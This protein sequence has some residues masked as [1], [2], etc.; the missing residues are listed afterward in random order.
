VGFVDLVGGNYALSALSPY[1]NAATDGTDIGVD[2]TALNA[3]T[4]CTLSG[5]CGGSAPSLSS[6]APNNVAA[7]SAGFVLTA[8]GSNFG[9]SSVVQWNGTNRMTA[10]V[11][12]TQLQATILATDVATPGTAQVTVVN[13]AP[14]GGTSNALTFTTLSGVSLAV[15]RAGTGSGT[16]TSTP[17]GINCGTSCS[18]TF[19]SGA[20]VVLTATSATGSVFTGWSGGGCSG[21]GACTVTLSAPTTVTATF[22]LQTFT[23]TVSKAGTGSGTVTSSPA[24]ITCGTTCSA[25]FASGTAV[26]LTAPPATGS[27][28][29]GWSGGGCSGTGACTVTLSAPTTVTASLTDTTPPTVSITAPLAAATVSGTVTV[30][31]TAADNVGVAGV[32][33][34]LDGVNL[35]AEVTAAPYT[36]AW[37][38]TTAANGAHALT[39]VARDAAGNRTTSSGVSVTVANAIPIF[40]PA[41]GLVTYWKFDEGTGT[42]AGDSSGNGNTGTLVNGPAW[43]AGK[44]GQALLFDGLTNYVSVP[45]TAA[46][47]SYPLTVAFWM[48][49]SAT[50]GVSGIVSKYVAGSVNGYQVFMNAGNLCAWYL[51]DA[52]NYVYDGSAC[53][54]STSGYND[55]QW[56]YVTFTVDAAGG[57]LY[58]DGLPKASLGWTGTPGA[59]TTTQDL[60]IGHYPGVVGGGFFQG[61]LDDVRIYDPSLSAADVLSLYGAVTPG[62]PPVISGVAASNVSYVGA[63][64]TWTTNVSSD[65]QVEYGRTTAYGSSTTQNLSLVTSHSQAL[66]GLAPVTVYHYRVKSRDAAGI[67]ATS[68][69]GTFMTAAP[70]SDTPQRH[71]KRSNFFDEVT[72]FFRR[73]F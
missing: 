18:A 57:K 67:L 32:Q 31:A 29:S 24:G 30:T 64:I 65:S 66:S 55:N 54:L 68:A 12:G 70:P 8:S 60:H 19:A 62:S 69:D 22:T 58:V 34:L 9:S 48:K 44:L 2:F 15:V 3:A 4:A 40:N 43:T 16:V 73:L 1:K 36:V 72:K 38:T 27:T 42:I 47:N 28:F 14:G 25:G 52:S 11:S 46:L 13:P 41:V 53:T 10:F 56:H 50:S 5:A 6:L 23:L 26:T 33:F 37:T 71:R 17:A 20:S 7:G 63:T 59:P 39:A 49:T 51:R 45:S 21:T 35:G 61:I